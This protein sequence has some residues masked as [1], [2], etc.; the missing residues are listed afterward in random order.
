MVRTKSQEAKIL[1]QHPR[2]EPRLE[3]EAGV[4]DGLEL[5]VKHK[6]LRYSGDAET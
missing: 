1:S 3:G 5:G 4:V 2:M 6:E